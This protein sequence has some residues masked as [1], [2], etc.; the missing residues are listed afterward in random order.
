MTGSVLGGIKF[1]SRDCNRERA[2]LLRKDLVS[3][4]LAG[5]LANGLTWNCDNTLRVDQFFWHALASLTKSHI[6]KTLDFTSSADRKNK[7]LT[8]PSRELTFCCQ[9]CGK[10][11][12]TNAGLQTHRAKAHNVVHPLRALVTTATCPLCNSVFAN[13]RGAQ[14]H[15]QRACA[16]QFTQEH[17]DA[18]I[19]LVN[20]NIGQPGQLHFQ[21]FLH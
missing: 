14:L 10:K 7:I 19:A 4:T 11:Y 20:A 12:G 16:K 17:I 3:C 2:N 1:D 15:V 9:Q 21:A 13:V 18:K 6:N 5:P 8:G